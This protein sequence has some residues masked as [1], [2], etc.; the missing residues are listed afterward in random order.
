VNIIGKENSLN[1]KQIAE[2]GLTLEFHNETA[3]IPSYNF[4]FIGSYDGSILTIKQDLVIVSL[5]QPSL[6]IKIANQI[7]NITDENSVIG[8][9]SN[10]LPFYFL[11]N[12]M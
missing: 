5:K 3:F 1:L 10:G 11:S 8:V 6:D 7:M 4:G 12:L 9:I 2:S